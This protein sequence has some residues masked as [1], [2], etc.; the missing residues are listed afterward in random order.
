MEEAT[1]DVLLL[2]ISYVYINI[3][4]CRIKSSWSLH[5]S[6][7]E[8]DF[9][10][11]ASIILIHVKWHYGDIYCVATI[12]QS[13]VSRGRLAFELFNVSGLILPPG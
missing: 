13:M 7:G 5:T 2:G 9:R 11:S 8:R 6:R 1:V 4:A 10:P 3:Y 12:E